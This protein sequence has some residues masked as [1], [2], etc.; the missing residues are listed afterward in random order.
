M[1]FI[2]ITTNVSV[3]E[4]NAVAV[5]SALGKA[6][7]ILPGKSENWLMVSISDDNR[8]YFK[9]ADSPAAMV[10]TEL[11]GKAD[12]AKLSALTS[13]I[14]AILGDTLSIPAD[15]IYVSYL[16]T[17]NWGWNGSNI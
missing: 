5:K 8:M 6:I 11:Y 12:P 16:C 3:S 13:E 15:R 4:E 10:K 2:S 9:G 1:P 17:E 7:S 14:T